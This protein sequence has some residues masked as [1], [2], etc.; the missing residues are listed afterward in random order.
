MRSTETDGGEKAKS[1][2]S[3]PAFCSESAQKFCGVAPA[4]RQEFSC[5]PFVHSHGNPQEEE[6]KHKENTYAD[7]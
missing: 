1:G 6:K 2:G 3:D 4:L 5:R 7:R